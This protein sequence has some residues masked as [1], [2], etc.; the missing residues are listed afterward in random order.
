[1][2][3]KTGCCYA[4]CALDHVPGHPALSKCRV[5]VASGH[6]GIADPRSTM[7]AI[8]VS[9]SAW[10]ST[11]EHPVDIYIPQLALQQQDHSRRHISNARPQ[12]L[13][14]QP[15]LSCTPCTSAAADAHTVSTFAGPEVPA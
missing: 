14:L 3:R 12:Q 11:A 5:G 9:C 4:R 13:P 6:F 10:S 15:P 8:G 7:M 2:H 1:M